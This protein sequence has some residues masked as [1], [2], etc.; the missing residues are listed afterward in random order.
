VPKIIL[1]YKED[2]CEE[3]KSGNYEIDKT[4]IDPVQESETT[5]NL[6]EI[7]GIGSKRAK[8]LEIAG[9]KTISDLAKCSSAHL[10]EK[11][12][13]PISQISNWIIESN[14]LTKRATIIS[15]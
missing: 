9:V 5:S 14:K 7:K 4:L 10:S 1:H 3:P 6:I 15:A 8:E 13:I 2:P 12:G 11:T